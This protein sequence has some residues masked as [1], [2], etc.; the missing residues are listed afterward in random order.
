[1][2]TQKDL[3]L[4]IAALQFWADEMA[5][6]DTQLL[7]LYANNPTADQTWTSESIQRLRKWL[8]STHLK[9]A[10]TNAAG[11]VFLTSE[12]FATLE[13]AEQARTD[14]SDLIGTLLLPTPSEKV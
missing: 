3:L 13:T 8:R 10:V 4:I 12:L 11:T 5:P 6:G 2:L 14:S 9:Y 7:K 1:M